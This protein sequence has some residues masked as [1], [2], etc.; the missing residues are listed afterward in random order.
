MSLVGSLEDLGLGDI[1][2]IISL[3]RKS[4]MLVL[5]ADAGDGKIVFSEGAIATAYVQG[6]PTNLRELMNRK[7]SVGGADLEAAEEEARREGRG[8]AEVLIERGL[9]QDPELESLRRDHVEATV[10]GMFAWHSG[11]FS[12]EISDLPAEV[13][14]DLFVTPGINPQFLALEGTRFRDE[15]GRDAGAE[16]EGGPLLEAEPLD[17]EEGGLEEDPAFDLDAAFAPHDA[18]PEAQPA[19][20]KPAAPAP[21]PESQAA[22]PAAPRRLPSTVTAPVVVVDGDLP[23]LEWIKEAL[24]PIARQVHIFQRSDH[25]MNRIRQYLARAQR[26][27]VLLAADAP[28]DAL[29]GAKDAREMVSRL[30]AQSGSMRILLLDEEGSQVPKLP[31][32]ADGLAL[33]PTPTHLADA[34]CVKERETLAA[35]LRETVLGQT[36]ARSGEVEDPP[37]PD[38]L[39]PEALSR[40]RVVGERLRARES[41]GEILH[42]V[43][44][45]ALE[46]F[47]RVALF[48]VRDD[49]VHGL[50]QVGL[51]RAGGPDDAGLRRVELPVREPAWFR[52]VLGSRKPL[53]AA[54]ADA[55]DQR[56]AVLLGSQVPEEAYVAPLE[57]GDRV[58]AFL[59]GDNLPSRELIGDTAALEVVLQQAGLALDRA[60]LER[61]LE[62]AEG[63]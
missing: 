36:D 44:Q 59:Y 26:P 1:L 19:A 20:A 29:S 62:K 15:E 46:T 21:E 2:Q 55:G 49:F 53:R 57:S 18:A 11:E 47:A 31:K 52:R 43:M 25:G 35:R 5:R 24:A 40:L 7:G 3:S 22:T 4:G 61:I 54:P 9:A 17:P 34:R 28:P 51:T 16:E 10:L 6:G 58:V 48:G 14:G 42:I 45:F 38:D 63:F 56:L 37:P 30:K 33:K 41:D 27:M 39:P 60:Y 12:F 8:L 13:S 23:S 50:A 32:G